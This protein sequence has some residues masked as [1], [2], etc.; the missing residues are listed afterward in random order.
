MA[1]DTSIKI[2]GGCKI[3][4]IK[5][6]KLLLYIWTLRKVLGLSNLTPESRNGYGETT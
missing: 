2:V 1:L 5:Q 3:T 6:L 4:K